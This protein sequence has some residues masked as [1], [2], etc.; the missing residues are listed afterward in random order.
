[1]GVAV[2]ISS[3]LAGVNRHG[4]VIRHPIPYEILEPNI[5]ISL[6]HGIHNTIN[7]CDIIILA[8]KR[9]LEIVHIQGHWRDWW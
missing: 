9:N 7:L 1:M 2:Q 3:T 5:D 4:H 6:V 8:V